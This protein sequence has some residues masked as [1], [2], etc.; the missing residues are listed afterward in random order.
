VSPAVWVGVALLGGAGAVARFMLD[1]AVSARAGRAFPW[2][3]LAVN[4]SGAFV[5]GLLAGAALGGDE[6][7]LAA[8]GLIAS[9][10]TFS[11]WALE[12]HRQG[13]DGR[14]RG[15][16][17]NIAGGLVLGLACAWAGRRIGMA[18]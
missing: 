4:L 10:T 3:T 8:T 14:L 12:A 5:L 16:A 2:G 15:A 17:L 11:T 6:R 9:Y 13:E 18:L 7:R 1:G